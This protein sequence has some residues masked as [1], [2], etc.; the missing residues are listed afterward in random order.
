MKA[1]FI[2]YKELILFLFWGTI[3]LFFTCNHVVWRDEMR[4]LSIVIDSHSIFDLA[5]HKLEN[6]GHPILWYL[7]LY[8]F[9][10]ILKSTIVLKIA[11]FTIG[12]FNTYLIVFKTKLYFI[13]KLLLIFTSLMFFE[14]TIKARNYGI[15]ITFILLLYNLLD[16]E[17][18]KK[19]YFLLILFS[20][21]L[22]QTN[23]IGFIIS[24]AFHI[25]YLFEKR[26]QNKKLLLI[27][28]VV[29]F[30][31]TLLF[32]LITKTNSLS[33]FFIDKSVLIKKMLNLN[34]LSLLLPYYSFKPFIGTM[35]SVGIGIGTLI[36]FL[37][38]LSLK[39][40]KLYLTAI[41]TL[42][43]LAQFISVYVYG[44]FPRH[45]GLII[46]FYILLFFRINSFENINAIKNYLNLPTLIL[47]IFFVANIVQ[48]F[49]TIE[50]PHSCSKEF[51]NFINDEK[52]NNSILIGERDF[53]TE[54][55]PY[56]SD[57]DIYVPREKIYSKITHFT[58]KNSDT[59]KM[60]EILNI[61]DS[62]KKPILLL[63]DSFSY[64]KSKPIRHFFNMREKCFIFDTVNLSRIQFLKNFT[65]TQSDEF[66]EL[67]YIKP[68]KI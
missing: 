26:I 1:F 51:A 48:I 34:S 14:Y 59:L 10:F 3:T 19:N 8:I 54:A 7:I 25:I 60:S 21:L 47:I 18:N 15:S 30:S 62:I 36:L 45:I 65:N 27:S 52:Y 50:K 11:S 67:Y 46:I 66:Y 9:Y 42:L 33:V 63:F 58:S 55:I 35:N 44:L 31:N 20:I 41:Y 6:E 61:S 5:F 12:I 4:A 22:S 40:S 37:L 29:L 28:G 23:I 13:V 24:I 16:K 2:K 68:R 17:F 53:F 39:K 57:I 32:Y 49:E 43:I 56:Y 38:I 64:Y